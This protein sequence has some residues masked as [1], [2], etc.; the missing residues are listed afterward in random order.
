[1]A[2]HDPDLGSGSDQY[3]NYTNKLYCYPDNRTE[4]NY[5]EYL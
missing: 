2:H 5:F 4:T 3:N 1:M